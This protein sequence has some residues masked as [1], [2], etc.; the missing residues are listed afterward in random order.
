MRDTLPLLIAEDGYRYLDA[1]AA[2]VH[3]TYF[4]KYPPLSVRWGQQI[5]RKR[6][7]SIRLGS[8]N[9]HTVEIR[10]HPLLQ[11]PNI[12]AFFN[13]SFTT[14]TCITSSA[15]ATTAA[16]TPRSASSGTTANRRNGF[17]AT[18]SSSS[19]EGRASSSRA[20]LRPVRFR[21]LTKCG[22]WSCSKGRG[23]A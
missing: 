10:I 16:S 13:R 23:T 19:G 15:P 3:R 7:R 4:A 14:S 8:Y 17:A 2:E 21:R 18:S 12:P 11:A 5:S 22:R 6:R 9:H 1:L 20:A